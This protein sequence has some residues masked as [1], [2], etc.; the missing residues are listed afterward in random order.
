MRI[1]DLPSLLRSSVPS[2]PEQ[3]SVL[4]AVK[5]L[6]LPIAR[7]ATIL[8]RIGRK[9]KALRVLATKQTSSRSLALARRPTYCL[10]K[11]PILSCRRPLNF[12]LP[13][14][15]TGQKKLFLHWN[16]GGPRRRGVVPGFP[17]RL[18][19]GSRETRGARGCM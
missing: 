8:R 1:R 5:R 10:T 7:E 19:A 9:W 2:S 15:L 18:T 6:R 11:T 12:A 4:E 16:E 14:L 3:R 17:V 13:F